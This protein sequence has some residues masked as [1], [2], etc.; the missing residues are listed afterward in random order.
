MY[1]AI[2]TV[3]SCCHSKV[4][5]VFKGYTRAVGRRGKLDPMANLFCLGAG[6]HRKSRC[7]RLILVL[8]EETSKVNFRT[9]IFLK[10]H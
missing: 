10:L 7:L 3:E 8:W 6:G 1:I 9:E 2:F 5:S 4:K